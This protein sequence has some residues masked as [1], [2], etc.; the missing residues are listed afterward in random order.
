MSQ[1]KP[2]LLVWDLPLRLFHWGLVISIFGAWLTAEVLEDMT[3]HF[4][5]GYTI[6]AL[7][8]FRFIWGFVGPEY[9]RFSSFQLKISQVKNYMQQMRAGDSPA[10]AGHNPMGSWSVV[11]MLLLI[12][13]QSLTGLFAS[14]DYL[15]GPLYH[16][17]SD[18]AATLLTEIHHKLFGAIK[19]I[20]VIHLL[21]IIY[22][23]FVKKD[24][25]IEAMIHG[26]KSLSGDFVAISSS[27]VWL[28]LAIG[29]AAGLAVYGIVLLEP[30]VISY[31]W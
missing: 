1:N 30:D 14:D 3:L 25:L 5:C 12:A 11:L 31:D 20:I 4:Y 17:A 27:R 16:Y 7:I 19:A 9:A 23:Q 28:A 18:S 21:A 15:S 10:H 24:G 13:S 6:F 2:S 29:V 26:R 8:L 22:Y